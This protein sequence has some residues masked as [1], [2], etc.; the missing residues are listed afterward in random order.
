MT[1]RVMTLFLIFL[2]MFLGSCNRKNPID[3]G[4]DMFYF[5]SFETADDTTGWHG[6]SSLMFEE[7]AAPNSGKKSLRIGGG[8][9]QPTAYRTFSKFER[10]GIFRLSCWAKVREHG[11]AG[12]LVLKV[13][14]GEES[15]QSMSLAIDSEE[16]TFFQSYDFLFCMPG[17]RLKLEIMIGG[18][19]PASMNL[20]CLAIERV[21]FQ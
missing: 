2:M 11:Q 21:E 13:M 5:N 1:F 19:V 6:I 9:I 10:N 16:W 17:S 14:N 20:D 18:I 4:S 12:T 15:V 3:Q 7:D 8:C